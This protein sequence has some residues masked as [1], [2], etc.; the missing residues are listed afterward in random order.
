MGPDEV[1]MVYK[2]WQIVEEV[3]RLKD[4]IQMLESE[5]LFWEKELYLYALRKNPQ[6]EL[7]IKEKNHD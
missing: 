1:S 7:K 2:I 6:L 5:K 3:E 4:K